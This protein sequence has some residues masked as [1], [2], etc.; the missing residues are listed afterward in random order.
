MSKANETIEAKIDN[1]VIS[2]QISKPQHK[3]IFQLIKTLSDTPLNNIQNDTQKALQQT[4]TTILNGLETVKEVIKELEPEEESKSNDDATQAAK[5]IL[6]TEQEQS[7]IITDKYNTED[8]AEEAA[9]LGL[10]Q[11][12]GDGFDNMTE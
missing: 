2:Q 4:Q 9:L 3:E 6:S 12:F 5:L 10:V 7:I 1:S 8:S 11:M